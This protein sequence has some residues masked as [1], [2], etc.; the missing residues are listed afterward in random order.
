MVR[1][2]VETVIVAKL[3]LLAVRMT[4]ELL[5][6]AVGITGAIDPVMLAGVTLVDRVTFPAKLFML[7]SAMVAVAEPPAGMLIEDG[8]AATLKS[9][10]FASTVVC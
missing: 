8:L 2:E 10:T 4:T 7:V 6:D 1:R 3:V 5:V 9:T